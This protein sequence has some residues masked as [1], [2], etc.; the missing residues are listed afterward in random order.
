VI[1]GTE[2]EE[3]FERKS[4]KNTALQ[5]GRARANFLLT[6]KYKKKVQ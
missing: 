3:I 5:E 2:W 6:Y 4:G 1:C